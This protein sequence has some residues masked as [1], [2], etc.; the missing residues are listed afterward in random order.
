[1]RGKGE[2]SIYRRSDGYWVGAVEA[3]RYPNG[4]RRKVR[5]VRR[6]RADVLAALDDLRRQARQGVVPDQTRTTGEFLRWWLDTVVADTVS[7]STRETYRYDIERAA[8]AI[9]R[10]KLGKLTSAHV[11]A[12]AADLVE[13]HPRSSKTRSATLSVVR[14]ALRYAVAAGMLA[15]NPADAVSNPRTK[16]AKID[17]VLTAA[18]AKA[19]I[20]A[21][22]GTDMHGLVWLALTYGLRLG[23]LLNLRWSDVDFDTEHL[24]VRRSK[25]AAGERTVPLLPEAVEVLKAHRRR[26]TVVSP[27]VFPTGIGTQRTP[28]KTRDAWSDVLA[29]A[30]VEHKCR[31]CGSAET[32]S[33]HVRRFHASRHTA[34]TLLLD[35]GVPL[36]IVSAILGHASLGITADIYARVSDDLKRRGLAAVVRP[37][38]PAEAG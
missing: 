27:Y 28:Q 9:G 19:V 29:K 24:T 10:V 20:G 15:S 6:Y 30:G 25:T 23:E 14:R 22:E 18:E 16:T 34:A 4:R 1:M 12:L 13:R 35:R 3:G 36:E 38:P 2:G 7:T 33:T 37:E 21:A 17:D 5:V 8:P 11:Q 26:S 32:C 31:N